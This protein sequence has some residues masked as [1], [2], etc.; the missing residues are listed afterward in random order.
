MAND[1][2]RDDEEIRSGK[3]RR[4]KKSPLPFGCS[5][6]LAVCGV[7]L[8]ICCIFVFTALKWDT[9]SP[10]GAAEW[11]SFSDSTN[12][13]FTSQISGISVLEN[14]FN[15]IDKGLIYVSDTSI[16]CLNHDGEI[17]FSEQHNFTNPL[18]KSSKLYSIAFNEGGSNF[19]ILSEKGEVHRGTQG[20]AITDCD[21]NDSGTYC[22]ISDQTGYLSNLSVYDRNNE[23]LYS[24]YF[25][26]FYA[27]SVSVSSDGSKAAVGAVNSVDGRLVSKVYLLDFSST[28]PANVYTYNDQIVY[29]V[30]F[31]EEEK[32]AVVTD[33]LVSVIDSSNGKESAYSFNKRVL[34]A[35][36]ISYKENIVL[37][38][39]RS[40][41]GRE[42]SVVSL[43]T[44]GNET[45]SFQTNLKISSLDVKNDRI[46]VLSSNS[47]CVF[48]SYGD[49]FGEWEVGNDAKAALL[50]QEKTAYI[51]GVS[52]IRK[53]S[54]K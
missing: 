30:K 38:L 7:V 33:S 45:G 20:T 40:D 35:Y 13:S 9:L 32:F 25:N 27:V 19:R 1:Y 23:F 14:N 18:I 50:P 21:I 43:D 47:L 26:D 51:L 6:R 42:C 12:S 39:S 15:D 3:R 2:D 34:T 17:L 24:Y 54:L 8:L 53:A 29:E 41:D 11:F 10:E 31:I 49:S 44:K 28:T 4:K 5:S 16:V 37:S 36:N 46:A 22:V 52:E 48:N